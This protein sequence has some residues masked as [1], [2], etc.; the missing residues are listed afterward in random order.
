MFTSIDEVLRR[1]IE[2]TALPLISVIVAG[3]IV[4]I[5]GN[6]LWALV[7]YHVV[8]GGLWTGIDCSSGSLSAQ[9]SDGSPFLL[10]LSS[11][12]DSCR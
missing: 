5:A 12:H 3:L 8:G 1:P 4:T 2:F 10:A 11:R 6:W 9:F 7:F